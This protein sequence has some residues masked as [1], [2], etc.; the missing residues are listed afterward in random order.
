MRIMATGVFISAT[1]P[2]VLVRM[3]GRVTRLKNSATPMT[4]E[5]TTGLRAMALGE[6]VSFRPVM[7]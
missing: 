6:M 4:M 3:P 5:I 7:M 1:Y 2:R